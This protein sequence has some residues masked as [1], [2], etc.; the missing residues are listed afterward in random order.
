MIQNYKIHIK[1][2]TV[3]VQNTNVVA[4]RKKDI[5]KKAVRVIKDGKI[6]I[7]G[8]V[9]D[10]DNDIL[11]KE[12]KENLSINI[13]Y[14]Y[15]FEAPKQESVIFNDNKITHESVLETTEYILDFLKKEYDEFD[16]SETV[17]VCDTK[18]TFEDSNGTELEYNDSHTELG[19]ILKEK[20][21]ANLFDGYI[22]YSGRHLDKDLFIEKN[23]EFLDAYRTEVPMPTEEKLPIVMLEDSSLKGKLI[24]ELNGERYGNGSSLL[25]NKVGEKIF[26]EKINIIQTYNPKISYRPFFDTEGVVNKNYEYPLV[27]NGVLN[28][29][30]TNKKIAAEYDLVHTG[31]ASGSYD[32]VPTLGS[33]SLT[34]K[35]DSTDFKESIKK[36]IL[37]VVAAGGDFTADGAYASPVQKAFL[38]ENGRIVGKLPEFQIKSHLYKMYGDDYIGTYDSPFYLE[39]Y[40]KVTAINM[41]IIK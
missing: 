20:S 33:T 23:R 28:A 40:H 26:D 30:F 25:A 7:S 3:R 2:T 4:V 29:C 8:A 5:I 27:I 6:G 38:Y 1:E 13:P 16:F 22:A 10:V 14:A 18:V 11:T 41:T 36:C 35:K 39:D 21:S 9:G 15:E 32:D 12:A 37:I 34:I 17:K 24:S 31:S 19:L